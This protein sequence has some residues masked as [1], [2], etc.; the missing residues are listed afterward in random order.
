MNNKNKIHILLLSILIILIIILL[1]NN[2]EFF[3]NQI[4]TA[5]IIEPREHKAM[6][7]VLKNFLENLDDSWNILILHGNKNI[8][9]IQN[10]I[11]TTLSSYKNRIKLESLGVDNLSWG[12]YS[13][14]MINPSLYDLIPTE[15]FMI[16]Q[17]DSMIIPKNKNNIYDFLKYD[18]VG[19]PWGP[20]TWAHAQGNVGNG[21]LSLRRKSKM[22]EILETCPPEQYDDSKQNTED[23]YFALPCSKIN[24]NKP[25]FEEAKRFASDSILDPRSFGIHK[26]WQYADIK[27]IIEYFP[28]AADLHEL[29]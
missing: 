28:E 8:K 29:Q 24:I 18:Y 23:L 14:L 19:G 16:F 5:V 26:P 22:L 1:I 15:I 7:F 21:G 12:E 17:T 9:Y 27:T 25:T 4:Y 6:E 13:N 10:I 20:S 3:Q 2:T 11:N